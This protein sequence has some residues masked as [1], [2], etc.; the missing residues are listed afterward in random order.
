MDFDTIAPYLPSPVVAFKHLVWNP[1]QDYDFNRDNVIDAIVAVGGCFL[2]MKYGK[3][4]DLS[5]YEIAA[6]TIFL[7]PRIGKYAIG[8]HF[9]SEG[10]HRAR[11]TDSANKALAV[12]LAILGYVGI[13]EAGRVF[14][15][16]YIPRL[17]LIK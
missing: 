8:Y 12:G 10:M 6:V 3:A 9:I 13:T 1:T 2:A 17:G 14:F 7:S 4:L 16:K 15:T 11:S 5:F